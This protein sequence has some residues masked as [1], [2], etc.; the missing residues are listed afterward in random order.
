MGIYVFIDIILYS[1]H[2]QKSGRSLHH[3]ILYN[4]YKSKTF[5]LSNED[6][7]LDKQNQNLLCYHYTIRQ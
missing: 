1:I 7:N 3:P 2:N 6:S 5:L 4:Y